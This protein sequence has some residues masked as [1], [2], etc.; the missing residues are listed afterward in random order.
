MQV[1]LSLLIRL[2]NPN[3]SVTKYQLTNLHKKDK[4]AIQMSITT[5]YWKFQKKCITRSQCQ[6]NTTPMCA[7]VVHH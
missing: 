6:L 1:F 2:V 4:N 5:I 3:P 7:V